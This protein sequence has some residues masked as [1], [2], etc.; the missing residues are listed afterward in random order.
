M[1]PEIQHSG[2][3]VG[4]GMRLEYSVEIHF[5]ILQQKV[6]NCVLLVESTAVEKDKERNVTYLV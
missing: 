6:E 1:V 3:P 5:S 4:S 2:H